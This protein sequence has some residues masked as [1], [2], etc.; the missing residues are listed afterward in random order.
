[1]FKVLH[2]SIAIANSRS[3][4]QAGEILTK[5]DDS[6][7]TK[8][9]AFR[10]KPVYH[11]NHFWQIIGVILKE[12]FAHETI[13]DAKVFIIRIPSFIIQFDSWN[14]AKSCS[15]HGRSH[16]FFWK[17]FVSWK[18]LKMVI[19]SREELENLWSGDLKRWSTSSENFKWVLH[20][21]P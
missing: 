15:K 6:N 11:V 16:K 9:G 8:F 19:V 20:L 13:N 1:M 5:W 7:Y 14:Q 12:V 3:P 2:V 4:P 17:Q 21:L 10:Q 18:V